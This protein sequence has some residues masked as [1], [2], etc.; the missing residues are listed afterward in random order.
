[1][2]LP[3]VGVYSC[4]RVRSRFPGLPKPI[5]IWSEGDGEKIGLR[6]IHRTDKH[7]AEI[8]LTVEESGGPTKYISI[9]GELHAGPTMGMRCCVLLCSDPRRTQ[10][11]SNTSTHWESSVDD[12]GDFWPY[13][14]CDDGFDRFAAILAQKETGQDSIST[15][16]MRNVGINT[17]SLCT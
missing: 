12:S 7:Y 14:P 11:R 17:R 13:E 16:A 4:A 15:D 3:S 10:K 6:W 5:V 9:F 1:M 8:L 2:C